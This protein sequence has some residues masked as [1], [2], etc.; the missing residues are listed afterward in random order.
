MSTQSINFHQLTNGLSNMIDLVGIDDVYHSK[1]VAYM[2]VE[3]GRQMGLGEEALLKLYYAGQL[4]DCGVSSTDVHKQLINEM[5]WEGAQQHSQRG[6]ELL[7]EQTLFAPL[8]PILLYHHTH[9]QAMRALGV[10]EETALLS[11]LV[12]LA[13]R[14]DALLLQ[15]RYVPYVMGRETIQRKLVEYEGEYF[16]P[17]LVRAFLQVSRTDAFW[18]G[19]QSGHIQQYITSFPHDGLLPGV[20]EEVTC[21]GCL[22]EVSYLIADIV[23]AKSQY[24]AEH[25][26]GVANLSRYLG[27]LCGLDKDTC[28]LLEISGLLHDLGKLRVPDALLA[29]PEPLSPQE[30]AIMSGHAFDTYQILHGMHGF[31]QISEWAGFHHEALDGSGYPFSLTAEQLS[32]E[33]RIV[34]V[35]DV[36]HALAQE[37]P[38]KPPSNAQFVLEGLQRKAQA[39]KIDAR[40]V[41]LVADNL[42]VCWQVACNL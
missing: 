8:A 15:G 31:E 37:R 16:A 10:P 13:D 9:W 27:E 17:A 14:A 23:D 29:K 38:Y 3:T 22:K 2:C 6:Y 7:R 20:P 25:S 19:L 12:F 30:N 39:G 32:L 24:T 42:E 21:Q 11:N 18:H 41:Q 5:D 35:A 40:L 33:A 4:H 28:E 36:F 34:A 1:R 26:L